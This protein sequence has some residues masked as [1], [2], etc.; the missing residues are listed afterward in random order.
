MSMNLK[1]RLEQLDLIDVYNYVMDKNPS[2]D[3]PY[4]SNYHLEQ[5]TKLSIMGCEF[6]KISH[7]VQR[8]VAT[9]ALFH[10][11]DHSGSGKDDNKNI[12]RS[13]IGFMEF[14]H[15]NKLF[16]DEEEMIII[17]MIK[18]T[19][20]PY[21]KECHQLNIMQ[22]ILRDS[23]ILQAPFA[24]NY[25]ERVVLAIAKEANLTPQQMLAGQIG[26]MTSTKFCTDWATNLYNEVLPEAIQKV[27]QAKLEYD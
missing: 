7:P 12:I 5:V 26:F 4:H 2:K 23:D 19:R 22:Q 20:Y 1:E 6:H 11:F 14:N 10:D 24:E 21:L 17:N 3:L 8:L 18:E 16:E 9:A 27:E 25:I 13:V 15:E